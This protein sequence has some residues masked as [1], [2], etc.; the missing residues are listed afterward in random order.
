MKNRQGLQLSS[1]SLYGGEK[2][3]TLTKEYRTVLKFTPAKGL[4]WS[5]NIV[6]SNNVNNPAVIQKRNCQP[7][8]EC[9][10]CHQVTTYLGA[11]PG[12]TC[13]TT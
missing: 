13:V 8:Y 2:F 5:W 9:P 1:S 3:D 11:P 7:C 12:Y 6:D 4:E 10:P